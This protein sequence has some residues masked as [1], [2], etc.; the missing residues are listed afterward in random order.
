MLS[1]F[2][3]SHAVVLERYTA[4][5][6]SGSIH[7]E[8][9]QLRYLFFQILFLFPL[10]F[11][12]FAENKK[13]SIFTLVYW[14]TINIDSGSSQRH[15]YSHKNIV[16]YIFFFSWFLFWFYQFCRRIIFFSF[17][18]IQQRAGSDSS[19]LLLLITFQFWILVRLLSVIRL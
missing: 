12:F 6:A 7:P 18:L 15:W 17:V 13:S 3:D 10:N 16:V 14:M 4:A 11:F 1:F 9:E 2:P 8:K 19:H 5:I